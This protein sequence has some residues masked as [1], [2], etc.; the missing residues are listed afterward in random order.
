MGN[1]LGI[2][3]ILLLLYGAI[4]VLAIWGGLAYSYAGASGYLIF[5]TAIAGISAAGAM[6]QML[7]LVRTGRALALLKSQIQKMS[8]KAQVGL[9]MLEDS[10]PLEGLAGVVNHYITA[11]NSRM[12]DLADQQ[13]E[14]DIQIQVADAEKQ[15][16]EAI[17]QSIGEAVI[18]VNSAGELALANRQAEEIFGFSQSD[19]KGAALKDLVKDA[20]LVELVD[21]VVASPDSAVQPVCIEHSVAVGG[22]TCC[23]DLTVVPVYIGAQSLWAVVVVLHDITHDREIG[24]IKTE[25]VNNV[26]HELRSPLSCIKAYV[27][28]LVDN[29][30]PDQQARDDCYCSIASQVDRLSRLIDNILNINRIESGMMPVSKQAWDLPGQLAEAVEL[31]RLAAQEKNITLTIGHCDPCVIHA[32]RDMLGQAI[33]NLLSNAIKYTTDGG[34]VEI[35]CQSNP[36]D[37]QVVVEISDTG[38]GI[39]PRDL[40]RVFE[41]FYRAPNVNGIAQGTGLGL[42][43]VK[44]VVETLHGGKVQVRSELGKGSTF[45]IVLPVYGQ[46]QAI[47]EPAQIA[48]GMN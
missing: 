23:Y 7:L 4:I 16:T 14:L 17:I 36:Q 32:D 28:M 3:L 21:K 13:K 18:V 34:H 42:A 2:R 46:V 45:W 27:E 41:K 39:A 1:E 11:L 37:Q 12:N 5:W 30:V 29:E 35:A 40:S 48:G 47:A 22:R 8:D 38:V 15:N 33:G 20:R 19:Q 26:S 6:L 44:Q 10:E 24:R 9:V 31:V 25:F 43:V